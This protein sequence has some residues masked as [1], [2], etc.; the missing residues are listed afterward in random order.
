MNFWNLE[1]PQQTKS[2]STYQLKASTATIQHFSTLLNTYNWHPDQGITAA[3]SLRTSLKDSNVQE[4]SRKPS[5]HIITPD[6]SSWKDDQSWHYNAGQIWRN[7][8]NYFLSISISV[9]GISSVKI[10]NWFSSDAA[11]ARCV[12]N[13]QNSTD[14]SL[15]L[16]LMLG[17][18]RH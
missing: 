10:L 1:E 16:P 12:W 9:S 11:D 13:K 18:G 14:S 15:P 17:V 2:S 3:V 6:V 4:C 8:Q 7:N 5:L